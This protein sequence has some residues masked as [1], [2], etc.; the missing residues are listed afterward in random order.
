MA[1]NYVLV[2]C[3]QFLAKD[4]SVQ[5]KAQFATLLLLDQ[6]K[7]FGSSCTPTLLSTGKAS[8]AGKK[9]A[10][11]MQETLDMVKRF[12]VVVEAAVKLSGNQLVIS[13]STVLRSFE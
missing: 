2:N 3:V 4:S 6:G 13:E 7:F 10:T 12:N 1:T 5:T 11:I 9:A 8:A